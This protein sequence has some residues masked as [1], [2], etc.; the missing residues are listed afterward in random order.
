[1]Q[2][3]SKLRVVVQS[4]ICGCLKKGGLSLRVFS[5][6]LGNQWEETS[7]IIS[8]NILSCPCGRSILLYQ[9]PGSLKVLHSISA[10]PRTAHLEFCFWDL[11]EPLA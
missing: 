6:L 5:V 3:A 2:S 8:K 1:M 11:L 7:K 10:V 4:Q 9:S